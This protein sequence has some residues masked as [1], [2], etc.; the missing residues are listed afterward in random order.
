MRKRLSTIS[1][2]LL[3][4]A[5]VTSGIAGC[6]RPAQER[7]AQVTEAPTTEAVDGA[8]PTPGETVVSAVTPAPGVAGTEVA[9]QPTSESGAGAPAAVEPS[10]TPEPAATEVPSTTE[11]PASE[12]GEQYTL[13]TVK[14]GDTLAAIAS[15][16]DTTVEAIQQANDLKDNVIS[17]GQE[18]KIPKAGAS[19]GE[20]DGES[21]GEGTSESTGESSSGSSGESSGESTSGCRYQHTV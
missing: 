11:S 20:S 19:T 21:S 5:V 14:S 9:V 15:Q 2:L 3:V 13:S 18:L 7:E 8:T 1:I 10:P 6:S 16:H 17:S 4:M 12:E